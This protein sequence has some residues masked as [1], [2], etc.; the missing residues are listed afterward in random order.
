MATVQA[1]I[2]NRQSAIPVLRIG[3]WI[4]LL[5]GFAEVIIHGLRLFVFGEFLT[6]SHH[7]VWMIP[8][9]DAILFSLIALGLA[10]A[11]KMWP[12]RLSWVVAVGVLVFIA[13]MALL[14]M[15]P[16]IHTA[17]SLLIAAG[18]GVQLARWL[19]RRR[20]TVERFAGRSAV[21]FVAIVLLLAAG[22][23]LRER[24]GERITAGKLPEARPGA[25]NILLIILDTVRSLNM[26]LYGYPRPTTPEIARWAQGGVVFD[27]AISTAPWTLPSHA[28]MFTGQHPHELEANWKTPLEK[29]P[30][31]LAEAL[32]ERGYV[33]AGFVANVRYAGWETGLGRGFARYDDYQVGLGEALKSASLTT[34]FHQTFARRL[35]L[36]HLRPRTDA[37]DINHRFLGWID[38][39][40]S[41]RPFFV[42]LNYLD[43]H[44]PYQPPPSF[45]ARFAPDA[46]GPRPPDGERVSMAAARSQLALYDGSL[47]YLDS[48]IGGLFRE[49]DRRGLLENTLVVLTSDHGEEFAEHQILGHAATLYRPSLAVPLVLSHPGRVPPGRISRPVTLRDLARTLMDLSGNGGGNFP[50]VSWARLW[51]D[52]TAAP[53]TV[54]ASIR[55][56]INQPDWWP[57]SGGDMM[58][59][60][61]GRYRYIWN[62]G[63]GREELFDF[64]LD[65]TELRDLAPTPEGGGHLPA[66]RR[67]R[68]GFTGSPTG[69]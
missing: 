64:D 61:L 15:F 66:F 53:D 68:A 4:G 34:G 8:L 33:T 32:A 65:P 18:L 27:R 19:G 2:D 5:T 21:G 11:R 29:G 47:A 12:E 67:L 26:S 43:A 69:R 30:L 14:R 25:P 31:T 9:V 37:R 13:A 1:T 38:G 54:V 60:L 39:R 24:L 57:A 46:K 58:S 51:G 41:S 3:L 16:R 20:S 63:D 35:R 17:A 56:L 40:D 52:S 7:A 48:V 50:G 6:L 10:L 44:D 55:R 45:R 22:L 23:I 49:L 28:S 59:I 36:P 42:F 62:A